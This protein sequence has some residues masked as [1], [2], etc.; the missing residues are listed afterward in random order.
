M[1]RCKIKD[2]SADL[3]TLIDTCTCY[4]KLGYGK[5]SFTEYII[6]CQ[7]SLAIAFSLPVQWLVP[8]N[9]ITGQLTLLSHTLL[10]IAHDT[11]WLPLTL[12]LCTRKTPDK[13]DGFIHADTVNGYVMFIHLEWKSYRI[14]WPIN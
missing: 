6:C 5:Y 2:T 7:T 3:E 1:T 9:I 14:A 13:L 12:I 8:P 4:S 10:P 11:R